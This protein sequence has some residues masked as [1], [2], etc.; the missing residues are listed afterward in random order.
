VNIIYLHGIGWTEDPENDPLAG[1]F[2]SGIAQAYGLTIEGN[3]LQSRCGVKQ[4]DDKE[5]KVANSIEI[6]TG[7]NPIIYQTIIPGAELILDKLVCMDRQTLRVS[8]DL[9]FVIYRVFWDEIFWESLQDP[10]V[11]QDD[12]IG[13]S[14]GLTKLRRKYNRRLKDEM[15]NYGF[16]DAVMYLGPAGQEI[17]NAVKAAMCAASLDAAG[18]TFEKQGGSISAKEACFT[19]GKADNVANQFAFVSESLGSKIT[20]DVMREAL[21]DGRETVLDEMIAGTEIY[22]LANQIALLSLGDLSK[23]PNKPAQ[24][25]EGEARPKIVALSEINDFLSYEVNPFFENLWDRRH[26]AEGDYSTKFDYRAREKLRK[27]LGFDFVDIRLE[28]ADP[29]VG[30]VKDF[31]DPLQAH[32]KHVAEPEVVVL[33]LC[34][35]ENGEFA[36]ESCLAKN[37]EDP[38]N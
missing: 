35:A 12:H 32:S 16:S 29:I 4:V 34:G 18:Y 6:T 38:N 11:G 37:L 7:D 22:M 8:N 14:R 1:R 9:E 13:R 20:F 30:L 2:L 19:A 36:E 17:R 3:V 10:H 21:T 26:I 24:N 27:A 31:V 28:F 5:E 15:V 33:M 23:E 25:K